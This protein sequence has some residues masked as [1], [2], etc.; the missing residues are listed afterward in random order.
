[1]NKLNFCKFENS[2]VHTDKVVVKGTYTCSVICMK[3]GRDMDRK[4]LTPACF[5]TPKDFYKASRCA[6]SLFTKVKD[7]G[8]K[9]IERDSG[10]RL[11]EEI[12]TYDDDDDDKEDEKK[13]EIKSFD[14]IDREVSNGNTDENMMR[15]ME[16][17]ETDYDTIERPQQLETDNNASSDVG[18]SQLSAAFKVFYMKVDGM[19]MFFQISRG[20]RFTYESLEKQYNLWEKGKAQKYKKKKKKKK[21]DD[22]E[23]D[24]GNNSKF[25]EETLRESKE[26]K[27]KRLKDIEFFRVGAQFYKNREDIQTDSFNPLRVFSLRNFFVNYPT[28][29]KKIFNVRHAKNFD[30]F[31][32]ENVTMKLHADNIYELNPETFLYDTI[33]KSVFPWVP[34]YV[35]DCF[36][37]NNMSFSGSQAFVEDEDDEIIDDDG[38][39]YQVRLQAY[40]KV[41]DI[42]KKDSNLSKEEKLERLDVMEYLFG[43]YRIASGMSIFHRALVDFEK[44]IRHKHGGKLKLNG[45]VDKEE[46]DNFSIFSSY[47]RQVETY[48]IN[49]LS[50]TPQTMDVLISFMIGT[51]DA[52]D[53]TMGDHIRW[54]I[55]GVRQTSKSHTV[56]QFKKMCLPDF[57]LG[58]D[59][60][61]SRCADKTSR[62]QS[63]GTVFQGEAYSLLYKARHKMS[64][65]QKDQ[66]NEINEKF[67]TSET[68]WKYFTYVTLQNGEKKRSFKV[69]ISS[70]HQC[71]I[72]LSN[73]KNNHNE[74]ISSRFMNIIIPTENNVNIIDRAENQSQQNSIGAFKKFRE[75]P[76]A[77]CL[78]ACRINFAIGLGIIKHVNKRLLYIYMKS[79]MTDLHK[80]GV[81]SAK[82]IRDLLRIRKFTNQ[83]VIMRE[84]LKNYMHKGGEFWKKE[85]THDQLI[86]L[87]RGLIGD[88][89]A[90]Y[91]AARICYPQYVDPLAYS[92][93]DNIARTHFKLNDETLDEIEKQSESVTVV[94]ERNK[95][96]RSI[97][98]IYDVVPEN[99]NKKTKKHNDKEPEMPQLVVEVDK[100][101]SEKIKN[102]YALLDS[103]ILHIDKEKGLAFDQKDISIG[104]YDYA[105]YDL[106]YIVR[107]V[108]YTI[109]TFNTYLMNN[110]DS[111]PTE[112]ELNRVINSLR[113]EFQN[114]PIW[115][116]EIKKKDFDEKIRPTYDDSSKT[117]PDRIKVLMQNIK[118]KEDEKAKLF[119]LHGKSGKKSAGSSTLI[120]ICYQVFS[121]DSGSLYTKILNDTVQ[122]E[123]LKEM[124]ILVPEIRV[125]FETSGGSSLETVTITP[126]PNKKLSWKNPSYMNPQKLES[127]KRIDRKMRSFNDEDDNSNDNVEA[128]WLGA[129]SKEILSEEFLEVDKDPDQWIY[130]TRQRE[131]G[132]TDLDYKKYKG[133][134]NIKS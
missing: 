94:Q 61:G 95:A 90:C 16:Y 62:D 84:I 97:S 10:I 85:V 101:K 41:K 88:T 107:K 122:T 17:T 33:Q 12:P 131:L 100:T 36:C 133:T 110:M 52:Y 74:A 60:V 77:I 123:Y 47:I 38:I 102:A 69:S 34:E 115:W 23:D 51:L 111:I 116:E 93:F 79:M 65:Q 67:S 63:F 66:L 72:A 26:E 82:N 48:A 55:T 40:Y 1:M 37:S 125:K 128:D 49:Q 132:Y 113:Y 59:G 54:F 73:E 20:S 2:R 19:I 121:K 83:I 130:E 134:W 96:K 50:V 8:K 80:A 46:G 106:N 64:D 105:H 27:M 15:F 4:Y 21:N 32:R 35:Q 103:I 7:M 18:E 9:I 25:T 28:V 117:K 11:R 58:L 43:N 14:Q 45:Y 57:V 98:N 39:S 120:K 89:E 86:W 127:M 71:M 92:M 91:M 42:D 13:E 104:Y 53:I 30:Q 68:K 56:E 75:M 108:D 70:H 119:S 31:L 29:A 118:F 112:S 3:E 78:M 24:V 76:K 5:T 6:L 129:Y 114:V 126:N 44:S 81:K 22:D 99:D 109:K 87:E 124:S